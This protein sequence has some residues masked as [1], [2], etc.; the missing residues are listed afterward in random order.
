MKENRNT[1]YT[2]DEIKN[3]IKENDMKMS[4][5]SNK[6]IDN[7]SPLDFQ[8]DVCKHSFMKSL[9][10]VMSK[11][12]SCPAC[13]KN[14]GRITK[15][16]MKKEV[17]QYSYE[18]E[19]FI[20]GDSNKGTLFNVRCDRGH[21]Y[22]TSYREFFREEKRG[23][24]C[25]QCCSEGLNKT[26]KKMIKEFDV[27]VKD[28]NYRYLG[29]EIR[30]KTDIRTFICEN[31]HERTIRFSNFERHPKC[32]E[33]T[34]YPRLS[35][36]DLQVKFNKLGIEYVDGFVSTTSDSIITFKCKCGGFGQGMYRTVIKSKRCNECLTKKRWTF[37]TVTQLFNE[38]DCKLLETKYIN[39]TTPL[40]FICSCGDECSKSLSE[41]RN[42]P[43]CRKCIIDNI[44]K[45]EN[46]YKWNPNKTDEDRNDDR[47]YPEY[48]EWRTLVFERD[49]YTCQCCNSSSG[50][51]LQAHHILNYT[52]FKDLRTDV[53]NGITLCDICHT[54]F[55]NLYGYTENSLEQLEEYMQDIQSE[56]QIII[57][58][59]DLA[60]TYSNN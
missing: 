34:G 36:S 4:L 27:F 59:P 48:A 9:N 2:I 54:D 26:R 35:K 32:V 31:G 24:S 13:A 55:H 25:K 12:R 30:T 5:L 15:S 14:G 33:C 1:P 38:N 23:G 43:M 37:E 3:H 57:E 7:K 46:H 16:Q 22:I 49:G 18:I 45:G 39:N 17:A 10:D 47:K 56:M 6:Y 50:S 42:Y 44:P 29:N 58:A 19:E 20:G 40:K 51:N 8:C 28:H 21:K 41:F 52:E 60:H 53:N 11:S